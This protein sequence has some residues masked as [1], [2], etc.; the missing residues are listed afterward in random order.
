LDRHV[1]VHLDRYCSKESDVFPTFS[2]RVR[3]FLWFAAKLIPRCKRPPCGRT[4]DAKAMCQDD[5]NSTT[6]WAFSLGYL[7][8]STWSELKIDQQVVGIKVKYLGW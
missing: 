6:G 7:G 5:P 3:S 8:N 2:A 4:M 1:V